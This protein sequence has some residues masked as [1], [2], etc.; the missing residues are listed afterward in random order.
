MNILLCNFIRADLDLALPFSTSFLYIDATCVVASFLP[1]VVGTR[2]PLHSYSCN[3]DS[4]TIIDGV[5]V[6]EAAA[7]ALQCLQN[8]DSMN[9]HQRRKSHVFVFHVPI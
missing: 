4:S 5:L 6:E 1:T 8:F 3:L 7:M 2:A 9:Q